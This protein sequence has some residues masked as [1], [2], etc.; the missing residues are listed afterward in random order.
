MGQS[1]MS[2]KAG[3]MIDIENDIR[4]ATPEDYQEIFRLTCLLHNENGQFKFSEEKVK[5]LVW[6]G[7]NGNG[8]LIGVIGPHDN[9]KAMIYLQI[10]PIYYSDEFQLGEVFN[11]VRKDCRKSDYAKRMIGFAKKCAEETGLTV[12]IG[13]IS[14]IRLEPKRRLYERQLP[15]AGYWFIIRPKAGAHTIENEAA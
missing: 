7:C 3:R 9:I 12:S 14:D 15:L 6:D 5:R 11:F 13:I 4:T 8:A 2:D 1:R 10:Q